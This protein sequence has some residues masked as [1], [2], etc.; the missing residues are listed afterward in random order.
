MGI[1]M[2]TELQGGWNEPASVK[3]LIVL[4]STEETKVTA[5]TCTVLPFNTWQSFGG[6][7]QLECILSIFYRV[8][9]F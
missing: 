8:C 1:I 3:C 5:V 9:V 4:S 2:L 7:P 6:K